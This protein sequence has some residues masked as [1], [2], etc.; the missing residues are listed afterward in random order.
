MSDRPYPSDLSDAE[1]VVL[2]PLLPPPS[3]TGRRRSDH[4][5]RCGGDLLPR[6]VRLYM[7]DAAA[8]LPA[9]AQRSH[10]V[11]SAR[12]PGTVPAQL[13]RRRQDRTLERLPSAAVSD[14]QTAR[15]TGVEGPGRGGDAGKKTFGA[16]ATYA[17]TSR[18]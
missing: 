4:A 10:G 6:S 11:R 3:L 15:A 18:A 16:S 17:Q 7:A 1:R 14:W 9:I 2:R 13:A 8:T 5:E 12:R